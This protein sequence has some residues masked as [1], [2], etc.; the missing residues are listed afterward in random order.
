MIIGDEERVAFLLRFSKRQP[1][2]LLQSG[3]LGDAAFAVDP[4]DLLLFC[5]LFAGQNAR[6]ERRGIAFFDGEAVRRDAMPFKNPLDGLARFVRADDADGNGFDAQRP[7][8]EERVSGAAEGEFLFLIRKNEDGGFARD[9]PCIAVQIFVED[10]V[11]P[12]SDPDEGK[13]VDD[14]EKSFGFF[15]HRRSVPIFYQ[16]RAKR[17]NFQ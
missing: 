1:E 17:S 8:V 13:F 15:F 16:K 11:A 5:I 3:R 2:L 9:P 14:G 7:E 6:F 12:D 4:E 10:D